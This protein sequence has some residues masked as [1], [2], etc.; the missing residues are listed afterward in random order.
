MKFFRMIIAGAVCV[1]SSILGGCCSPE[2]EMCVY[3]RARANELVDMI[4]ICCQQPDPSSCL[5]EIQGSADTLREKLNEIREACRAENDE[6]VKS[7]QEEIKKLFEEL[8]KKLNLKPAADPSQP[9]GYSNA[10]AVLITGETVTFN[11]AATQTSTSQEQTL[12][13]QGEQLLPEA[14]GGSIA[15][16]GSTTTGVVSVTPVALPTVSYTLASNSSVTLS[17]LF[18]TLQYTASGSITTGSW[19]QSGTGQKSIPTGASIT[20]SRPNITIILTLDRSFAGNLAYVN[21]S[22]DGSL[23]AMF[24]VQVSGTSAASV[25]ALSDTLWL[26][27]PFRLSTN[28]QTLDFAIRGTQ[29][30]ASVIPAK[31]ASIAASDYYFGTTPHSSAA[32][33]A[34]AGCADSDG[35]GRADLADQI[36]RNS[37]EFFPECYGEN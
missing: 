34:P 37:R 5:A 8:R 6:L 30:G 17:T 35:N 28:K 18:D 19:T 1:A 11:M 26:S 12:E 31:A 24:K 3:V 2:K 36:A 13:V 16:E 23:D 15:P 32:V 29:A 10:A 21:A 27:I 7:L 4:E 22:G 9:S 25:V 14:V 20:L 33:Q